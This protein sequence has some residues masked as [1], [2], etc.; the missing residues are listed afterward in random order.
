[1]ARFRVDARDAAGKRVQQTMEAA[2]LTELRMRLRER[3]Y[4]VLSIAE[5][6]RRGRAAAGRQA[7]EGAIVYK[8]VG[9]PPRPRIK[10]SDLVVFTRQFSTM[11]GAGI[12]LMECMDILAEQATDPGF[13]LILQHVTDDVRAGGDLSQA[14]S[15]HPR[16]FTN[17][18]VNMV[19]A[20]EA[21]G[22]LDTMFLRLAQYTESSEKLKHQITAAMTYPVVSICLVLAIASVLLL[23]II[24][25]FATMF[26]SMFEEGRAAL[27]IATKVVLF[28]SEV[29]RHQI[30]IMIGVAVG[31]FIVIRWYKRT[32][33]GGYVWDRLKLKLP[34]L[35][36]IVQKISLS[37]F[38]RTFS[39]LLGS[40]VNILSALEIVAATAG[41]RVVERAVLASRDSIRAG[42]PLHRP[43]G[44]SAVFPPMV[45]RMV[46]IGERSGQLES[47]L[48]KISEFYDE[49]VSSAVESLTA[50]IE[51]L[52]IGV[53]GV[54]VG[55][56]VL[57]VFWP[58]FEIQG[59]LAK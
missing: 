7:Q 50:L 9:G 59:R 29:L 39:T 56:I 10:S 4:T 48:E 31:L 32:E 6:R 20:G 27:P 21:S 14:L 3:S 45:V 58:I 46:A 19:R 51:P 52:M 55:G 5:E 2:D 42:E 24:P 13:K 53:M 38:S 37:R 26:D 11:I 43:L 23:F 49:Q 33:G 8:F 41:N 54:M 17:L 34:I 35:G 28:I 12:T 16:V 40:G 47:L 18:Y 57:A 1:M 44:E 22:Q 25:K 36:P 30:H 15:K